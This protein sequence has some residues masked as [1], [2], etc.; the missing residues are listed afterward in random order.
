MAAGGCVGGRSVFNPCS[1]N[2]F[3]SG[4]SCCVACCCSLTGISGILTS[5]EPLPHPA[6]TPRQNTA[7]NTIAYAFLRRSTQILFSI[8]SFCYLTTNATVI[9]IAMESGFTSVSSFYAAF[10][11]VTGVCPNRYRRGLRGTASP[12]TSPA[13][14]KTSSDPTLKNKRKT[15]RKKKTH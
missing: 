13:L 10:K 2:C 11:R 5:L 15:A 4:V 7:S 14:R 9:D 12:D 8:F 3:C 6:K 1:S